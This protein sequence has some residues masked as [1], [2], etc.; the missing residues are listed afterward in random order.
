MFYP[1]SIVWN[2]AYKRIYFVW[3]IVMLFGFSIPL[4]LHWIPLALIGLSSQIYHQKFRTWQAK[5]LLLLWALV[6][7]GGIF[8][9]ARVVIF[10]LPS[11]FPITHF[12]PWWLGFMAV[13]QI[14]TGVVLKKYYQVGLGLLWAVAAV[15][16]WEAPIGI[17]QTFFLTAALTGLPY[18]F[19]AFSKKTL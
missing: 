12:A 9:N 8:L 2:S 15:L 13:P 18:L 10:G 3:G 17:Q 4:F 16:L 14:L 7:L 1:F 19:I 11:P 6:S 5:T